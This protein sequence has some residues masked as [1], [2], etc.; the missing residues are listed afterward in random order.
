[1]AIKGS[2]RLG[3]LSWS[4]TGPVGP[5]GIQGIPGVKGDTGLTGAKG[6]Q[7]I[8]G[9]EGRLGLKGDTGA[10]GLK[11]DTGAKGD[12]GIA[13]TNGA[14]GPAGAVGP[15]GDQGIP[16]AAGLVGATGPAGPSG[17]PGPAGPAGGSGGSVYSLTCTYNGDVTTFNGSVGTTVHN[18]PGHVGNEGP[19][20]T[21]ESRAGIELAFIAALQRL[22]P[23]QTAVVILADV[24]G[25]S[26][27]EVAG[28][29]DTSPTAVKGTLQRA[30]AALARTAAGGSHAPAG[31]RGSAA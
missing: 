30:R 5:Q 13:G 24:L 8:Q 14:T 26:T 16:G 22:P 29:L 11:G 6:D 9:I 7:G 21:S 17:A 12:Q 1:L 4:H 28:M 19:A 31:G 3:I 20:A 18:P 15:K 2:L 27:A 23:R 10:Q 25:F